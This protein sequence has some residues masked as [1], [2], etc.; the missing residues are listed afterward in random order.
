M[1][2]MKSYQ[3]LFLLTSK[4]TTFAYPFVIFGCQQKLLRW[5]LVGDSGKRD[6]H[7]INFFATPYLEP[8]L[9]W[10]WPHF[11]FLEILSVAFEI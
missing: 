4:A 11:V 6:N 2:H 1:E 9:E 7:L 8:I 3:N 10:S 5:W